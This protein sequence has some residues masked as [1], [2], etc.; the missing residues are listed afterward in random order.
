M[1]KRSRKTTIEKNNENAE[2][3]SICFTGGG[4]VCVIRQ[5][6]VPHYPNFFIHKHKTINHDFYQR[7]LNVDFSLR[8]H[9][10]L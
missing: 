8:L 7:H 10:C 6:I 5:K 3:L 1:K 4:G 2:F 9:A